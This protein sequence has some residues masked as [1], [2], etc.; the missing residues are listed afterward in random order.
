MSGTALLPVGV[1]ATWKVRRAVKL[2][3]MGIGGVSTAND[4]LQ[5]LLAGATLVGMGTAMLRDP[6]APERVVRD[7]AEWC[8]RHGVGSIEEIVG[9]VRG[10]DRRGPLRGGRPCPIVA[11]DPRPPNRRSPWRGGSATGAGSTRSRQ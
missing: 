6:R 8:D 4:A 7:L 2:P 3:L 10:R 11:L 5:Y 9:N 1:L